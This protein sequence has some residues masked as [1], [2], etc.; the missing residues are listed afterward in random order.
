M[1]NVYLRYQKGLSLECLFPTRSDRTCSCGCGKSLSNRKRKWASSVCRDSSYVR[2][3]IIKGDTDIIRLELN[4]IYNSICCSCGEKTQSWEADHIL[5]VQY[6]GGGCEINNFQ[7]LCK[8]CHLKKTNFYTL[9]HHS[10]I[11]SHAAAI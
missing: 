7:L 2:F 6:G 4:K 5:P 11:S 10:T 3:A 1:I 8:F 9:P